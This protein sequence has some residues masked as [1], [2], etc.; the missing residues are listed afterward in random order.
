[1]EPAQVHSAVRAGAGVVELAVSAEE[2]ATSARAGAGPPAPESAA[3]TVEAARRA[4]LTTV[5]HIT[6]SFAEDRAD[7]P[8]TAGNARTPRCGPWSRAAPGMTGTLHV[9]ARER[10]PGRQDMEGSRCV[11]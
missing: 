7:A 8:R 5:A 10:F 11:R 6:E 4:R 9:L 1:M 2:H 3:P